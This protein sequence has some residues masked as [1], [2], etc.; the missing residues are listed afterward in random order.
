MACFFSH[1]EVFYSV[2]S[3]KPKQ[4][5]QPIMKQCSRGIKEDASFREGSLRLNPL[6]LVNAVQNE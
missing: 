1:R 5:P 4:E 3:Q 6:E 2:G